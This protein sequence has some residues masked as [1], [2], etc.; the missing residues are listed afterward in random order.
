MRARRR[1]LGLFF[2]LDARVVQTV[3]RAAD[4]EAFLV[5]QL[6]AAADEQHLVVLV[7]AAVAAALH[8]LQLREFLLPVAQNVRLDAAKL[9]YFADGEVA[10]RRDRRQVSF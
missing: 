9:A 8:A 3:A 2:G 4:R 10:L 7:V 6:G 5:E 1:R